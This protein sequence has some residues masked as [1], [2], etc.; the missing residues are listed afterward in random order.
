MV[1]YT[2]VCCKFETHNKNKYERHLSTKKHI[3]TSMVE[4]DRYKALEEKYKAL[5]EKYKQEKYKEEKYKE[6]DKE[7]KE[8]DKE[9]DKEDQVP[10]MEDKV[11]NVADMLSKSQY[12]TPNLEELIL[13]F[14]CD[15]YERNPVDG[16]IQVLNRIPFKPFQYVNG[17]WFSKQH[18]VWFYD[19]ERTFMRHIRQQMTKETGSIFEE[20]IGDKDLH[21][22]K[23]LEWILN[24][25]KQLGSSDIKQ[26]LRSIR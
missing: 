10:I 9:N 6:D 20:H 4:D 7:E 16:M 26:I 19:K 8:D 1:A 2:C 11:Y 22:E 3:D 15:D 18:N 12:Q 23:W 17:R 24:S 25:F 13:D 5:E 14:H 21:S